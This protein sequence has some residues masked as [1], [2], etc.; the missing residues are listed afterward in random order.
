MFD[1]FRK[2]CICPLRTCIALY[3]LAAIKSNVSIRRPSCLVNLYEQRQVRTPMSL[4]LASIGP[5]SRRSISLNACKPLTLVIG[6]ELVAFSGMPLG[7]HTESSL[8]PP[9]CRSGRSGQPPDEDP[10][11]AKSQPDRRIICRNIRVL[12]LI[13]VHQYLNQTSRRARYGTY[14]SPSA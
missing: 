2:S 7:T 14:R 11:R 10:R 8:I 6:S 5:S 13:S 1:P 12:C 4:R 3:R 9:T